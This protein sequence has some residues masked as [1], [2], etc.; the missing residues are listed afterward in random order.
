ML[1]SVIMGLAGLGALTLLTAV[2]DGSDP[3]VMINSEEVEPLLERRVPSVNWFVPGQVTV[4]LPDIGHNHH[5]FTSRAFIDAYEKSIH[6]RKYE[7]TENMDPLM[8]P[9]IMMANLKRPAV[10]GDGHQTVSYLG[11]DFQHNRGIQRHYDPLDHAYHSH[12]FYDPNSF[13]HE[14]NSEMERKI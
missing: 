3:H 7:N 5:L 10:P 2:G 9:H 14:Y 8:D 4:N 13:L 11:S 1:G 6:V 12:L